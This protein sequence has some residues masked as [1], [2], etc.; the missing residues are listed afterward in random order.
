MSVAVLSTEPM[1][2]ITRNYLGPVD[3]WDPVG[4]VTDQSAKRTKS[5]EQ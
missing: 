2:G 1:F 4:M 5:G 3:Q